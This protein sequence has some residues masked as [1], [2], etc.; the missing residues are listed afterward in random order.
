MQLANYSDI[1]TLQNSINTLQNADVVIGEYNGNAQD[2]SSRQNINL[3]FRPRYIYV[4]GTMYDSVYFQM[5]WQYFSV[6]TS[7]AG[8]DAL[9][10]TDTGF[11]VSNRSSSYTSTYLNY[12]DRHYAYIAFR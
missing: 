8:N 10:T 3:G 12:S 4:S 2:T 11:S 5:K 6:A 7:S 1:Q 9:Y